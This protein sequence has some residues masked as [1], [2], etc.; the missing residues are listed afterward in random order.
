V[1]LLRYASLSLAVNLLPT[2]LNPCNAARCICSLG[3]PR[4]GHVVYRYVCAATSAA[5]GVFGM[6][7]PYSSTDRKYELRFLEMFR[8]SVYSRFSTLNPCVRCLLLFVYDALLRSARKATLAA[9]AESLLL[10]ISLLSL[11]SCFDCFCRA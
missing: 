6:M 3:S 10:C 4:L 5:S 2:I 7:L 9:I 11:S 8:I 1:P